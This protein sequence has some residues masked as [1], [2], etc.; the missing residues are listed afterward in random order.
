MNSPF[1]ASLP[2]WLPVFWLSENRLTGYTVWY[3][4]E[5]FKNAKI[6]FQCVQ[7]KDFAFLFPTSVRVSL[8]KCIHSSCPLKRSVGNFSTRFVFR[9]LFY[10]QINMQIYSTTKKWVLTSTKLTALFTNKGH[11]TSFFYQPVW[12]PLYVNN[13]DDL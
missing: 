9:R 2:K 3:M 7:R 4:R 5:Y 11:Y 10:R 8:Q 6:H 13:T 1:N 12:R